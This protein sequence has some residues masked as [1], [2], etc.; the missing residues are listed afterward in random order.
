MVGDDRRVSHGLD[1]PGSTVVAPGTQWWGSDSN[2]GFFGF[3]GVTDGTANTGLFSE[4]LLGW[5][6]GNQGGVLMSTS[7]DAKRG[8]YVL[9]TLPGPCNQGAQ[10][11]AQ[12]LIGVQACKSIPAGSSQATS[13]NGWLSGFSWAIGYEWHWVNQCYSH[14]NTPNGLTCINQ[15]SDPQPGVWGGGAGAVTASSNHPGGVNVCFADGSVRFVKDTVGPATW[16]ALGSRNGGEVVSSDQPLS[17][18]LKSN[19]SVFLRATRGRV[20]RGRR[21]NFVMTCS[22]FTQRRV[23]DEEIRARRLRPISRHGFG[24]FDRMRLGYDRGGHSEGR[25][26]A[27]RGH[28]EN[29]RHDE[30][31]GSGDEEYAEP[32]CAEG[33]GCDS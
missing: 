10:G 8:I 13:Q 24:R 16:W 14:Y 11:Q 22:I 2:L 15:A 30:G 6:N 17:D 18:S 4:K 21:S 3:E 20:A 33:R 12:A 5:P 32:G 31:N 26:C 23:Q 19:G 7:A 29:G 28:R 1:P 27:R 25:D 9:T